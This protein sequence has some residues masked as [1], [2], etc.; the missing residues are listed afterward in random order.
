[1]TDTSTS[2]HTSSAHLGVFSHSS[3]SAASFTSPT[4]GSCKSVYDD[5]PSKGRISFLL[6]HSKYFRVAYGIL[7]LLH[8]ER[9]QMLQLYA[10]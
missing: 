6:T 3:M 7:L 9:F 2:L 5:C 10:K 8:R 4:M 1:M